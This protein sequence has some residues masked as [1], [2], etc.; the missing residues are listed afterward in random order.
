MMT[1]RLELKTLETALS[2]R[3]NELRRSLAARNQIAV[4]PAADVFDATLLAAQRESS[5]RALEQE[6]QLLRQV[7]AARDRLRNGSFG[8]CLSCEEEIPP[9]RLSAIPWAAYCVPC[10]Q[11]AE[12]NAP[13]RNAWA[14]AA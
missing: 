9:K 8:S 14:R 13:F 2:M 4:E 6:F 11:K 1:R 3:A 7:E 5:A 10:Q 12:V